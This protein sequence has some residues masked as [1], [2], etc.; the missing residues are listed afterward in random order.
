M[1]LFVYL[2]IPILVYTALIYIYNL[3]HL[4]SYL[5]GMICSV[6]EFPKKIKLNKLGENWLFCWGGGGGGG[7]GI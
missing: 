6:K 1:F 5:P 2:F 3:Y 7:G 4:N